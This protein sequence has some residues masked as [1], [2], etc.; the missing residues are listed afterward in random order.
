MLDREHK[1]IFIHQRKC[2]GASIKVAFE[3]LPAEDRDFGER[4]VRSREWRS[5]EALVRSCFVFSIARNPWDRFVSGWKWCE[6]TRDLTIHELLHNLPQSGHDFRHITD[7]QST[8]ITDETG[9]PQL[10]FLMR[11]ET[12]QPD[13]DQVCDLIGKP[14]V[15]LPHRNR[16]ARD[17]DYRGYFD[18][19]ARDLFM[20]HFAPDVE[21]LGYSF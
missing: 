20:D 18:A 21:M 5:H 8:M 15:A 3:P 16:G 12:M 4:G 7:L 1:A 2:G 9:R 11:F 17:T 13:F 10:D 6:G 19:E 14:R